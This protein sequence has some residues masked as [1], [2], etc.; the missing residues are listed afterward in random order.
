MNEIWKTVFNDLLYDVSNF[1]NIKRHGKENN[2]KPYLP[3]GGYSQVVLSKNGKIKT[4]YIHR[5]VALTFIHN[6]EN[7]PEVNH[8][9][10]N[11]A[12]NHVSNLEWATH[13]ENSEHASQLNLYR[14]SNKQ[15]EAAIQTLKNLTTEQK[16]KGINI[17]RNNLSLLSIE[18]K[19]KLTKN[20]N[21]KTR[22]PID[23]FTLDGN[24]I[25]NWSSAR[26]IERELNFC[27][28]GIYKCCMNKNTHAYGYKWKYAVK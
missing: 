25:K 5:L 16:Q 19:R 1:G 13:K 26:E 8:I 17:K 10:G 27:S 11:K 3:N 7:K 24:F 9:D 15:K 20:A 4:H 12:N 6:P 23:Q 21:E 28:G 2:L 22:K 14:P 18:E